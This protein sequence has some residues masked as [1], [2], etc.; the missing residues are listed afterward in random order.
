MSISNEDKVVLLNV[1]DNEGARYA[2]SRLLQQ[3]GF[4]VHEA[5]T[6]TTALTMVDGLQP[7]MVL[8]DVNLPDM[9]GV[10]VLRKIKADPVKSSILVLQISA[11]A[12][13]APQA[14][15]SLNSGADA[16]LMEPVDADVLVATVK[17]LLRLR[18]A[19]REVVRS[20]AAMREANL[21]LEQLNTA[22]RRSNEDIERFAYI[23]SHDLQEPLRTIATHLQLLERNLAGSLNEDN[24][25]VFDDIVLASHRM[26]DLIRDVL[27]YSRA[28]SGESVFKAVPLQDSLKWALNNLGD[29]LSSA[30]GE[31]ISDDLPVVW[32]DSTQL[33][34]V[35]QN[36]VGN[37][38]KYRSA[39]A[40]RIEIRA[41]P[42]TAGEWTVSIRDNGIG[43]DPK[44]HERIFRPFQ[45]LH[46]REFE[47]TGIGL[48]LCRRIVESHG[49]RIWVQSSA[50]SGSTFVFNLKAAEP[51]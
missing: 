33:A 16:Y 7:D 27:A 4:Q 25:Q 39:A 32:G 31:V 49:G 36:L 24:R 17:A 40:P 15:T 51:A 37:A 18:K 1:D 19:E 5:G 8:L 11:S 12:I 3:A 50:G 44:Y 9:N 42:G 20:N 45:R 35:F 26:S 28:G 13:S 6:G 43:I 47:G 10:D 46:G 2:R 14:T 21:R 29:S 23:A 48:A 34:Q 30:R 38:L 22:L 41:E